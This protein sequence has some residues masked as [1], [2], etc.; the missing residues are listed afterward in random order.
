MTGHST[1]PIHIFI[2]GYW[3]AGT[4]R[5]DGPRADAVVARDPLGLPLLPGRHLKGLLR[6]ACRELEAIPGALP[7]RS[8]GQT[9]S[10]ALFGRG[11]SEGRT[12]FDTTPG[13]L[14]FGSARMSTEWLA[15]ASAL[16]ESGRGDALAPLFHTLS[17]TA[18]DPDKGTARPGSLRSSEVTVP[19]ALWG[20]IEGPIDDG[21][22]QVL[23]SAAGMVKAVGKHRTRGLGS[24]R[25]TIGEGDQG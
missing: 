9:W 23:V 16:A 8:D 6:H 15:Y 7:A 18:L 3:H 25:I 24:A 12:R 17:S 14:R 13:V 5:G 10:D 21:T 11:S 19:M 22:R 2:F 20:T 1:L 4:G